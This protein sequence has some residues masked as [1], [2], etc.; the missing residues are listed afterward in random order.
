[1]DAGEFTR[2]LKLFNSCG[3]IFIA[4]SDSVRQKL[5]MD[6][7]D[8]GLEGIN[9]TDLSAKTNLSRPAISHHLKVLKDS[10][11]VKPEK[12]GTQIFY[13]LYVKKNLD[14]VSELIRQIQ[15]VLGKISASEGGNIGAEEENKK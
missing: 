5:I 12:K 13:R 6:I 10:G 11:F 7:A 8:A 2:I 15:Q 3:S 9:V 1:M 14:E 4:L